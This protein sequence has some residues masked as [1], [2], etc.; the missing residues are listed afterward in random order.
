MNIHVLSRDLA[1][2]IA[3]FEGPDAS[4]VI[5]QHTVTFVA[6][7]RPDGRLSAS[8][9][10][11]DARQNATRRDM[12]PAVKRAQH[13]R[14]NVSSGSMRL[15]RVCSPTDFHI[16]CSIYGKSPYS[17]RFCDRDCWLDPISAPTAR[18]VLALNRSS[19]SARR[20][21]FAGRSLGLLTVRSG[22]GP[23]K[24]D[25]WAG[26]GWGEKQIAFENSTYMFA[27]AARLQNLGL[28]GLGGALRIRLSAAA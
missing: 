20:L 17:A 16:R 14:P 21:I 15:T 1:N 23:A 24:K 25:R 13:W 26:A 19:P 9:L 28:C 8:Q 22:I 3:R 12:R 11:H 18:S 6:R 27:F 4:N 7:L 10:R 5:D 2:L